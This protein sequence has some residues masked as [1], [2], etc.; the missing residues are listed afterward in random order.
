MLEVYLELMD[1]LVSCM[2]DVCEDVLVLDGS[3]L[4]V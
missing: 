4:V 1:G 3:V 2:I